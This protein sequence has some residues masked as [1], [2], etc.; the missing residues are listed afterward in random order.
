MS[1]LKKRFKEHKKLTIKY[2]NRKWDIS[3]LESHIKFGVIPRGLRERVVPVEHL[4]TPRIM[5]KSKAKCIEHG[6]SIIQLIVDEEKIQLD[7]LKVELDQRSK[8]LQPLQCEV[9]FEKHNVVLKKE[10]EKTQKH[11]M[12]IKQHKFRQNLDNF[13]KVILP[14]VLILYI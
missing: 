1:R 12:T 9:Y 13:K 7:E 4:H 5:E 3:S 10:I 8:E 11:L 6:L 2:L 14:K